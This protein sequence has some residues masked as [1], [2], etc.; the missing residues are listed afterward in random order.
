MCCLSRDTE[1][2][3]AL[4]GRHARLPQG[5]R[6]VRRAGT[7][8]NLAAAFEPHPERFV[9]GTPRPLVVPEAARFNPNS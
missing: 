7:Q 8:G 1:S 9:R 3:S 6:K 5:L 2:V 4:Q